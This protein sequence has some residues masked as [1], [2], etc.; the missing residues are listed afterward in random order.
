MRKYVLHETTQRQQKNWSDSSNEMSLLS[1]A[2]QCTAPTPSPPSRSSEKLTHKQEDNQWVT[3]NSKFEKV[4][5][6]EK[7]H[8]IKVIQALF[9]FTLEICI[10]VLH[11]SKHDAIKI[12]TVVT[13]DV[14]VSKCAMRVIVYEEN[15]RSSF[16]SEDKL[17]IG[18]S[19]RKT[20]F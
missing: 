14:L 8:T 2:W 16:H 9:Y 19:T 1:A 17:V 15:N 7:S 4:T 11:T 20:L 12:Q 18:H 3:C 10:S 13:Q 6:K 5:Y